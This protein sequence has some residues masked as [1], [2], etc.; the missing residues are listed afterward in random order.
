MESYVLIGVYSVLGIVAILLL[1][2]I[3]KM[4]VIVPTN[5]VHI[6]QRGKNTVSYGV[7]KE[8]N[9]YYAFP[10]W[11]PK[12]GVEVRELPVSN[13]DI[14][15]ESYSAYDKDR[16]PFIVDIKAFF[17]ISDTNKA[18]EK[19]SSFQEL[20]AQLKNIVEGTVRSI[21][22]KSKLEEIM[23]ERSIFGERF[24]ENV[25]E[26]LKNWGVEPIKSIELMD[27]RD[28]SGSQVI[29]QIMAKRMSAIEMESRVEVA[30]NKKM[31]EQAELDAI[32]EVS[33]KK[34]ETDKIAG[35][36]LARS[37]QA[38]GIAKAE[39][40][41]KSGIAEQEAISEIAKSE[42]ETA[43]EKMEVQKINEVK[44]AEIDKERA[45]IN[46]KEKQ[47][48]IEI[49][50]DANKYKIEVDANANLVSKQKEAEGIEMVGNAEAT[51][52]KA[53]GLS[54][55]D[56]KKASE[57]ASVVA[58]TE[59][60]AKIGE[61]EGYQNYLIKVKEVEVG[62][63]V[64][65]E[66]YR[67]MAQALSKADLKLLVNSGDVNSGLSKFSD[68]LTSKGASQ[69]N[70]IIETLK[71]TKEGEG[72]LSLLNG[73]NKDEVSDMVKNILPATKE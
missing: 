41:K 4:R 47:R 10:K 51:V 37:E 32:K 34:A 58:Q 67:A 55:A 66:Q 40:L 43:K 18:A 22:A 17:A 54:E 28:G 46:A 35:E 45:I 20:K 36:A 63:V 5:V 27:V 71:Q 38:I 8:S 6:V 39:A 9:V 60:A 53:K 44:Q 73:L 15:L 48:R 56:A 52:I 13:F 64:G 57:L 1:R 62:Q 26:D 23:E 68:I 25:K 42:Q 24:T 70:N 69:L 59:L 33:V 50:T 19:V 65:I 30:N 14:E 3:L 2:W 29:A 16:V 31:A 7:G 11:M 12:I 21:L 49:E 61:N 72:I